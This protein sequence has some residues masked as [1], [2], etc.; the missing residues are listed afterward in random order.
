MPAVGESRRARFRAV[1]VIC[2]FAVV[3][4]GV[5]AVRA[6]P[7]RAATISSASYGGPY[8]ISYSGG[9]MVLSVTDD[10]ESPT[11]MQNT[12]ST[13]WPQAVGLSPGA[14]LSALFQA[15]WQVTSRATPGYPKPPTFSGGSISVS[16]STITVDIPAAVVSAQFNTTAWPAWAAG[17]LAA[18]VG[19]LTFLLTWGFCAAFFLG[20][21]PGPGV[22]LTGWGLRVCNG[23]GVFGWT[24]LSMIT[25]D[26]LTETPFTSGEWL[27]ILAASLAGFLVGFGISWAQPSV[28]EMVPKI[29]G[30]IW[31]GIK[32][33]A[34][35]VWNVISGLLQWLGNQFTSFKNFVSGLL[36]RARTDAPA[37]MNPIGQQTGQ[38]T[39][40]GTGAVSSTPPS[41]AAPPAPAAPQ[42]SPP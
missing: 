39:Q 24:G 32:A 38:A 15:T 2:A 21:S 31:D 29:I 14:S 23:I 7:A 26:G 8:T 42:G 36:G 9:D 19:G 33:A 10:G 35:A 4:P 20:L 1:A 41:Q 11:M 37:Q 27:H 40:R 16:G 12:I 28:G 17:I 34:T 3:I 25:Y 30:K 5:V 22:V 13:Y 6:A 18:I